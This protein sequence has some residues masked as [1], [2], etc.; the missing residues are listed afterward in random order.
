MKCLR[1]SETLVIVLM[2]GCVMCKECTNIP[3]ELSSHTFRYNLLNSNNV[4][5][6][7]E[8]YSH[9]D[10][11]LTPTDD[12]MWASLIPRKILR[13]GGHYLSASAQM[14]ASTSNDTLKKK[15][16]AVVSA[17][18]ECQEKIGTGYLS[19]F[20]SKFFDRFEAIKPVWAPYYT[21]HKIM[22]GLVDQVEFCKSEMKVVTTIPRLS[23]RQRRHRRNQSNQIFQKELV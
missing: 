1:L 4:T 12:N 17:L 2:F 16:T 13:E 5:Y 15:M 8:V 6:K 19:A 23:N 7:E 20:T 21:I 9:Y 10:K 14:W 11:H 3:T 22:A 18:A